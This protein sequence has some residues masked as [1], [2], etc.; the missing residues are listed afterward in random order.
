MAIIIKGKTLIGRFDPTLIS[1]LQL[2][3]DAS[4]PSTLF[5]NS[6][7]TIA[8]SLDGDPV[9]YWRD[10][11]GTGRN[12]KQNDGSM[13]PLLKIGS[14]TSIQFNSVN[15]YLYLLNIPLTKTSVFAVV[16][17]PYDYTQQILI[18]WGGASSN[19][20]VHM[21]IRSS[22]YACYFGNADGTSNEL[23]QSSNKNSNPIIISAI[24]DN[25]GKLTIN[26]SLND[27]KSFQGAMPNG[28][29]YMG[30]GVKLDSTGVATNPSYF[31]GK[32]YEILVYDNATSDT[33]VSMITNYLNT[34]WSIY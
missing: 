1:G 21:W 15:A 19:N 34:K 14:R 5:Q 10:K 16:D 2:W 27:S 33:N 6:D 13:K 32:M 22:R 26:G 9:G 11:S 24:Y 3:L 7:G 20:Q 23:V 29:S 17:S 4:D 8:A 12:A 28:T 18:Q 31:G 25:I 30:L